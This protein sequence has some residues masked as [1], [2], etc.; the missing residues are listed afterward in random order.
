[1]SMMSVE[2]LEHFDRIKNAYFGAD[3]G[4]PL[5]AFLA[6]KDVEADV[7]IDRVGSITEK[8]NLRQFRVTGN[9]M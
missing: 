8:G 4:I 9:L 5:G 1:M 6:L 7:L 3:A 2:H